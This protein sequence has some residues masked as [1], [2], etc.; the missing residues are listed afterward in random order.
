MASLLLLFFVQV[1]LESL[2]VSSSGHLSLLMQLLDYWGRNGE[3]TQLALLNAQW[4]GVLHLPTLVIMAVYFFSPFAKRRALPFVRERCRVFPDHSP[5]RFG[6]LRLSFRRHWYWRLSCQEAPPY[7]YLLLR[8]SRSWSMVAR[9]A[10][11]TAL[12]NFVTGLLY[13]W[14][15]PTLQTI[16]PLWVGFAC[17]TI[18]LFSLRWCPAVRPGVRLNCWRAVLLGVIH[19]L[20]WAP[21]ISR[22]ATMFA[23]ARWLGF[24]GR[25][26]F[27]VAWLLHAPL[28]IA[29]VARDIFRE[30]VYVFIAP[31]MRFD[32]I[33]LLYLATM[34][35]YE[36]FCITSSLA[37]SNKL[38]R[39]GFYTLIPMIVAFLIG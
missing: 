37:R 19:G 30:G 13:F 39:F 18:I 33:L 22:L 25:R 14:C 31:L 15:A 24:R 32:V 7:F 36:A 2:P 8:P 35:G 1:V 27:E 20:L 3:A 28:I 17:T 23:S 12:S 10:A 21:G 26:A 16:V 4:D 6:W 5:L 9:V 38:W 11:L 29:L 34:L